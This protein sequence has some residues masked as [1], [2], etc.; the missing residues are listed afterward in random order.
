MTK[1]ELTVRL[2]GEALGAAGVGPKARKQH[3]KVQKGRM[4]GAVSLLAEDVRLHKPE[5]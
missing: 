1:E 5:Q 4:R 3:A 2:L